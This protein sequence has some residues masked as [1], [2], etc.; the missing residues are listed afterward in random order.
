MT[1]ERWFLL[2]F[3]GFSGKKTEKYLQDSIFLLIF[4]PKMLRHAG[5][6]AES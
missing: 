4:A 6:A 2:N 3:L 5:V 1:L